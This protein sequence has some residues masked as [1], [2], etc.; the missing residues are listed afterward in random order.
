MS[1][2][3]TLR[4]GPSVATPPT[5][6]NTRR[7]FWWRRN[8]R[9]RQPDLTRELRLPEGIVLSIELA[10]SG[11]RIS[12]ALVDFF[13]LHLVFMISV[14][15]LIE[16]EPIELSPGQTVILILLGYFGIRVG[17]FMLTELAF[18]G[19]TLGKTLLGI[20]VMDRRG[21]PLR[22]RAIIARNLTREIEMFIPFQMALVGS[23][24]SDLI[25]TWIGLAWAGLFVG[26]PAFNRDRLRLGDLIA[27]TW[28]V[29][30]PKEAIEDDL[31]DKTLKTGMTASKRREFTAAQLDHYGIYELQTLERVLRVEGDNRFELQRDVAT[32]IANK[33]GYD[34]DQIGVA[35]EFLQDFYIAQRDRLETLMRHGERRERKASPEKRLTD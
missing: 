5:G 26:F 8:S 22:R 23:A 34:P 35:G 16:W 17:F 15:I 10:S 7:G 11:Q 25:L 9:K 20:R 21:G 28:V 29:E 30:E 32:K 31:A 3:T 27:G 19:A 4:P 2:D 18:R 33:I 12:A 1:A 13:L 14:F 6:S 24:G